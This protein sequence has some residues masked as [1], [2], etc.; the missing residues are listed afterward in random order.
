[1][2]HSDVPTVQ[3][4]LVRQDAKTLDALGRSRT[5]HLINQCLKEQWA[6]E[7]WI[8]QVRIANFRGTTLVVFTL[9]AAVLVPLRYKKQALLELISRE[10][11]LHCTELETKVVP[12]H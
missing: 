12:N 7:P 6:H 9:T 1:M 3:D 5:L 10:F 11:D 2:P 8:D 4:W